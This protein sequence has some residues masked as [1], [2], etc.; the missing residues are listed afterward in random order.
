[1]GT[2]RWRQTTG[3]WLVRWGSSVV[4]RPWVVPR[5][6]CRVRDPGAPQWAPLWQRV[7]HPVQ[8]LSALCSR[9]LPLFPLP[10]NCVLYRSKSK[11]QN[12]QTKCVTI[13]S[14]GIVI[15]GLTVILSI[16]LYANSLR[17]HLG[18]PDM[19]V[20]IVCDNKSNF[21]FL[22][23]LYMINLF[24]QSIS[25]HDGAV[26]FILHQIRQKVKTINYTQLLSINKKLT[27]LYIVY[28]ITRGKVNF[29]IQVQFYENDWGSESHLLHEI[30]T[31]LFVITQTNNM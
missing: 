7:L 16:H 13:L 24:R 26:V 17:R 29:F 28:F 20:R 14:R 4:V 15:V 6:A 3:S 9:H 11:Q 2:G 12:L 25:F 31:I 21:L 5:A 8:P 22:L 19:F 23:Y 1:M 30:W 27:A 18:Q 10:K